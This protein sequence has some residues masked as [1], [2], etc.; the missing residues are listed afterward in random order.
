MFVLYVWFTVV[1]PAIGLVRSDPLTL[2]LPID[3]NCPMPA[4]SSIS[5]FIRLSVV[6]LVLFSDTFPVSKSMCSSFYVSRHP[7]A[8]TPFR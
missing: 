6:R 4:R 1:L 8:C 5:S 7:H 3:H 2:S